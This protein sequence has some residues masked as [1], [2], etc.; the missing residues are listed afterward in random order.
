MEENLQNHHQRYELLDLHADHFNPVYSTKELSLYH[1][2]GTVDPLVSR[3]LRLLRQ[4][5]T[6]IIIAPVW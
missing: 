3:Y 6:V 5:Q 1:Q 4:A 2:G